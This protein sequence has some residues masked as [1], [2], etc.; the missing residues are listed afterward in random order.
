MNWGCPV[1]E[2][3][4]S[5]TRVRVGTIKEEGRGKASKEGI[6]RNEERGPEKDITN[7]GKKKQKQH[8]RRKGRLRGVCIAWEMSLLYEHIAG[9]I[10]LH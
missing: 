3:A 10:G 9:G 8:R 6:R 7:K 5:V 4:K 1:V 2:K